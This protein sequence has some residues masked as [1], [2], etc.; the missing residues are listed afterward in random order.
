MLY[1]RFK[2]VFLQ[3]LSLTLG[4][5]AT[6]WYK[7][8]QLNK[9]DVKEAKLYNYIHVLCYIPVL[10]ETDSERDCV[11]YKLIQC[12]VAHWLQLQNGWSKACTTFIV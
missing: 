4:L 6:W 11:L 9:G 8:S 3:Q 2:C 10:L 5:I 12:V 7:Y 1:S